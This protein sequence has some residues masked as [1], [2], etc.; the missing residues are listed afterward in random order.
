MRRAGLLGQVGSLR[1]LL[2]CC[3]LLAAS[4]AQAQS[5]LDRADT[6]S[7]R[8]GEAGTARA[9]E[10]AVPV[11]DV[12]APGST[13]RTASPGAAVAIGAVTILGLQVLKAGDFADILGDYVG[14]D[15]SPADLEALAS[16]LAQRTRARGYVFATATILPQRVVAGVLSV[17]VDEGSI[18]RIRIEGSD[19]KTIQ[20]TLDPLVNGHPVTLAE[21]ERR[22][23]LVGD[24]DG[25]VVRSTRYVRELGVGVLVV[26]VAED[27]IRARVTL[28]NDG[29]RPLGP[30]QVRLDLG[31]GSVLMADDWVTFSYATNPF[32]PGEINFVRLRY[33]VRAGSSG[34][35]VAVSGSYAAS[36]PGS[37]LSG[38]DLVG[39][40]LFANA[41]LSQPLLRRRR[42]SL[43]LNAS[44]DLRDSRHW[45]G[46]I[47][48]RHDRLVAARIG[49]YGY[50]HLAGGQLRYNVTV[51]QGLPIFGASDNDPLSS[52]VDASN[53]FTA[54]SIWSDYTHPIV[55]HL[56][57]RF[58]G[59]VQVAS[60]PLLIAEQAGL[61]GGPF[62]RGY[63]YGE[64][65]GDD[66]VMG[67]AE[68]QYDLARR[69]GLF[70]RTQFYAFVDGGR[71][72]A[73]DGGASDGALASGGGGVRADMIEGLGASVELAVP[74]TGPRY[75]TGNAAPKLNVTIAKSF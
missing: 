36:H 46:G 41:S 23:L 52:R 17:Y 72:S 40:D 38:Y 70:R 49:L 20:A 30:A 9:S 43:W 27:R 31:A 2:A 37:Y 75:D 61:G 73:R 50:D 53:S 7:R 71:V 21:V 67:S 8:Q 18:G 34:T 10:P 5:S 39:H 11:V 32:Q 19:R 58:A 15:C 51:S 59:Q 54:M 24:I 65:V 26:R 62:L 12:E 55:G 60:G 44:L 42:A 1:A 25:T 47:G 66:A 56:G 29:T 28:A 4:E 16:R 35:E 68:L 6:V 64:R 74:L 69:A 33:K 45:A 22:L 63:D 57:I 48:I 14:K 13:P 3:A